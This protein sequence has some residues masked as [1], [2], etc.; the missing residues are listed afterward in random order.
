LPD[1]FIFKPKIPSWVNIGMED[2]GIIYDIWSILLPF[3]YFMIIWGNSVYFF[4]FGMLY[5]EKSGNPV[6]ECLHTSVQNVLLP[7]SS[8]NQTWTRVR[9]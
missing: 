5:Q 6:L 9:V 2:V 1:V 3:V 8:S 7:Q 4:H